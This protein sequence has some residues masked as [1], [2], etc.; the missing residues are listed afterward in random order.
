MISKSN[1]RSAYVFYVIVSN[2]TE[3]T[4][5]PLHLSPTP[6]SSTEE[7]LVTPLATTETPSQVKSVSGVNPENVI[8]THDIGILPTLIDAVTPKGTSTEP[9][10]QTWA[11]R[12]QQPDDKSLRSVTT[13]MLSSTDKSRVKIHDAVFFQGA[14]AH[15]EFMVGYFFGRLPAIG[16]IQNVINHMWGEREKN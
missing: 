7:V 15:K 13:P 1:H 10:P 12:V 8:L 14:E 5:M 4:Q 16:L 3:G 6:V 9:P 2:L 11:H